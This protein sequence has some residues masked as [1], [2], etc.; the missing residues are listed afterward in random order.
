MNPL[1]TPLGEA[2]WAA[3]DFEGTGSAPGQCDEAVQ[4]GIAVARGRDAW[5]GNFFRSYVRSASEPTRAAAAV[6]GI[7]RSDVENAPSLTALWPEI[8]SR[9]SGSVVVAHGAGTEK[10][11]LRAFPMHG[12]G[13]WVDTLALARAFLP[14]L[15]DHALSAVVGAC[16]LEDPLR[17]ACPGLDWHDALFDA[18]ACLVLLQHLV[19]R[20]GLRDRVVGQLVSPDAGVYHRERR[21]ARVAREAGFAA[22]RRAGG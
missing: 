9:L 11:F 8:K 5:P 14:G 10:R 21:L 3:I 2:V 4:I 16:G 22:R 15:S 12:F 7:R 18:V 6:H 17:E 19:G 13:P 20:F 1:D